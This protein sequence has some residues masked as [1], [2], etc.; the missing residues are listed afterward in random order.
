[1]GRMYEALVIFHSWM[2]W[3]V[4]FA[5]AVAFARGA[6]GR[7]TKRS[8]NGVDEN[9]SRWFVIS[10]DI[11]VL[12]GLLLYFFYSPYTMSAWRN[13]AGAMGDAIARYWMVEHVVGMI[14]AT[15][16]AHIGRVR[17]RKTA[18]PVRRHFLAAVFF[19]IA[20]VLMLISTPWPFMSAARPMWRGI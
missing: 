18:D 7:F 13:M 5:A 8:W 19:G 3:V 17:I 1:M 16:F 9:V 4:L 2:R 14:A 15:A 6:A 10:V 11:Q 20:L 12:I